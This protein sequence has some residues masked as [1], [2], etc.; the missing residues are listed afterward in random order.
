MIALLVLI[1]LALVVIAFCLRK[2]CQNQVQMAKLAKADA[3]DMI[4]LLRGIK[5]GVWDK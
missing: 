5:K 1:L 2:I 4:L 3:T